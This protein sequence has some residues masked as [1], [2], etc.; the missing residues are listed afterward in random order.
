[1]TV[2]EFF[3]KIGLTGLFL[4]S[5]VLSAN[6]NAA[7]VI[8]T[9]GGTDNRASN[10]Q[11]WLANTAP[12]YGDDVVF[13]STSS[14][15]CAWD[16]NVRLSSFAVKSGYTGKVTKISD[17]SL[18]IAKG[19]VSPNAPA[20]LTAIVVSSSQ[21]NLSWTDNSNN[22]AGFKI[23]RK[24]GIG[25]T[26]T[27][28]A[29]VGAD[30]TAYPDTGL[31]AG[32]AYYYRVRAYNS[33]GDSAYSNEAN[34]ATLVVQPTVITDSGISTN[35]NSATLS[36]TVNPN[37][38]DTTVYFECGTGASYDISTAPQSIGNGTN[39]ITVSAGIAGLL[40]DTS[41]K[42]RVVVINPYDT[43]YGNDVNF[44]TPPV[45][46]TIISPVNGSTINRPDVLVRGTVTNITGNE[47]G[48]VANGIVATDL[49]N[50]FA[51]NH[52]PL[53][54]GSNTIIVTATDTAGNT[55]STAITVSAVTTTP[56]VRLDAN[57]ESGIPSLTTYFSVSTS[58][59]NAVSTY[60]MD[61]EG[62][63][64]IDYS[65]ASFDNISF[66]YNIEGVYYPTITVTDDKGT[67]YSDT[68]A[69][70]VLNTTELYAL[71]SAK[72]E[73]V[74]DRLSIRDTTTAL[75]YI[76]SDTRASY[77]EMFNA[78]VDQLPSI[79]ATQTE[80]NIISVKN[81]IAEYKLITNENG[82]IYSYE[83]IF[84]R[85]DNSGIWLIQD[86]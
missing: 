66:T 31:T 79:V 82:T 69:I 72:W 74:M 43:F 80:F 49:G 78:L 84:V 37:G 63:A 53:N 70:V 12:Q 60:Q 61:Y 41:Y 67:S 4:F 62:D 9:G 55:A 7:T 76:S 52:V 44:T 25:G 18:T 36:A 8:W 19:F 56:Y 35:G 17:A 71:L 1:M 46:L 45:T 22:E 28:I 20:G 29:S 33:F 15:D 73:G 54:E 26:Y 42:C 3:K 51:L 50:Q 68:I 21:I 38:S 85:D 48:V 34:A 32:T 86:F 30:V 5:I 27:Q 77:Q 2:N 11:N 64:V 39:A 65:G 24:A 57:I 75:T 13:N 23:E 58:I 83:V 47:T 81:N 10:S 14:K 59:P 16:L 40:P 6:A